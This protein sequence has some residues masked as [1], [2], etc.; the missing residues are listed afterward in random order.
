MPSGLPL[1]TTMTT[2]ELLTIPL[3]TPSAQVESTSFASTSRVTSGAR[4]NAT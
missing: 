4:L 2:T 1:R 3:V